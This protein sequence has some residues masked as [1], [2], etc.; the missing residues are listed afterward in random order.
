MFEWKPLSK[1]QRKVFNWWNDKSPVKGANGIIADGAIRSGKTLCMSTSFVMWSMANF[2]DE[3]FA[4]CGLTHGSL[5]RNVM[6]P[7]KEV[8]VGRGY[9]I[10][11]HKGYRLWIVRYK[12]NVNRF[13]QFSGGTGGADVIQGITLAGAFF[14]EAA[15][16]EEEF[17]NQATARCS[18]EGSK[19]WFNCNPSGPFHWFKQNW[20]DDRE[21][22][23]ILYIHFRIEDNGSLPE[24]IIERY[25]HMYSGVF[26]QRF[27]LGLW[28]AAEGVVYDMFNM[29]RH[30]LTER[31]EPKGT[32]YVSCDYGTQNPTVFLM[33]S[34]VGG[35]WTC[36][37]EYR[38]SGRE[39]LRQKT[40][41]EYAKDMDAWLGDI[42]PKRII[43]DPSAASFIEELKR[44]GYRIRKGNN[45]V[46]DG[47]R[48]VSSMLSN[49]EIAFSPECTGCIKEFGTYMWDGKAAERGEDKPLKENDHCM[50]AI[51]YFVYTILSKGTTKVRLYKDGI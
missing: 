21:N 41:A 34:K 31:A 20:I 18:V 16:M 22:K 11:E 43:V 32:V 33:W 49:D 14:D 42:V 35:K 39:N 7:L 12:G 36:V 19:W 37:R 2:T 44:H 26:Y 23:D 9:D 15:L 1:K 38:Y 8:L 17:V 13:Y 4:I 51:R 28:V 10:E 50:D 5:K 46:I 40:D 29:D 47:I 3:N 48:A 25:Y 27:I 24:D 45:D 6:D 30:V